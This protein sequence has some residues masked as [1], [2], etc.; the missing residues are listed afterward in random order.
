MFSP[1][2]VE[3]S[4]RCPWTCCFLWSGC[5]FTI[6]QDFSVFF[7]RVT[8]RVRTLPRVRVWSESWLMKENIVKDLVRLRVFVMVNPTWTGG[9]GS[10][11]RWRGSPWSPWSLGGSSSQGSAPLVKTIGRL[12]W[13]SSLLCSIYLYNRSVSCTFLRGQRSDS[14]IFA[15]RKTRDD[16]ESRIFAI[17]HS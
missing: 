1:P 6:I 9:S 8:N 7:V 17:H 2:W 16:L 12:A 3:V 4:Q 10:R 14:P 15:R 13:M 11:R 5:P